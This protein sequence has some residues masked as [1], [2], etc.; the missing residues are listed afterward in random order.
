MPTL[1]EISEQAALDAEKCVRDSMAIDYAWKTGH[2]DEWVDRKYAE[3]IG[4]TNGNGN[5]GA[6]GNGGTTPDTG[7]NPG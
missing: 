7:T 4:E 1:E 5:P 3:L 6:S 2:L